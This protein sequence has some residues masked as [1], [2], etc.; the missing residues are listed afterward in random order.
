MK[1]NVYELLG[2]DFLDKTP[3]MFSGGLLS[4]RLGFQVLRTLYLSLWRLKPKKV[5]KEIQQYVETLERDGIL[6]IPNFFPPDQ[7]SEIRA[8]FDKT[9]ADWNPLDSDP[10]DFTKRQKDFP[11]YFQ[12]IA[13]K[14]TFPKTQAF[15]NYFVNNKLI[16]EITSSVVHRETRLIPHSNF[17]FLQRKSLDKNNVGELHTAGLP[18]ADVSYPTIKVF[19]YM[20]DIDESNAAYIYAKKSHKLTL[21]RLLFEY[22]VSVRYSKTKK[23]SDTSVTDKDIIELGYHPKSIC[24]KANTLIIS[25]NMG[26][27]N[28]G[29]FKTLQPRQ[30]AMLD[31]RPLESWRN[32][33]YR[34]ETTDIFSRASRKFVK[35]LDKAKKGKLRA[36]SGM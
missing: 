3:G 1:Q 32:I 27:H 9:Y 5:R 8:E 22:N 21:K 33:L 6:V 14:R 2:D 12:T 28:R 18:H 26:F 10:S 34:N 4:N 11:E 17:E 15:T 23:E 20:N 7:F 19:L 13:E 36:S 29:D 31:F 24:G 16:Q 30:I 25:N 35:T